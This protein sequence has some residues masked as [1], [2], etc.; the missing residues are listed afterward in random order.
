M[1]VSV[2]VIVKNEAKFISHLLEALL[3]QSYQE[4]EIVIVDNGST[5]GVDRQ[6][7]SFKDKRIK[8]FY[9]PS[10]CGI[11]AS[12][13]QGIREAIGKYIFF[14]DGDCIPVRNWIE[15]GLR[16]LEAGKFVGVEGK[17]FYESQEEITVSDYNTHQFVA[18]EFMSCNIAYRRDILEKVNYFDPI[19]KYGHEDRDLAHRV[20]QVGKI[21]FC[22]NMLVA[23]QKK[24]LNVEA[25]FNRAKR[26][27]NTVDFIKKHRFYPRIKANIL[28]PDRLFIIFCPFVLIFTVSYRTFS[29]FI[30]G[31]F[32]YICY[33]YERLL[34]WKAAIKN[35][36]LVI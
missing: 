33:I 16:V 4:F 18:G 35:R 28:Y 9:E 5:D 11:A 34:I 15:E 23:H 13:N 17:T 3:N 12:R 7:K 36:I 19:F 21:Y 6:I 29:D 27:E 10:N 24:K 8:Y 2:I 22:S 26:V 31:F 20:L 30:L 1:K 32:K 14:T 25:L